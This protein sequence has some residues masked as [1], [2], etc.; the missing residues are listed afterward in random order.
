MTGL[1][2]HTLYTSNIIR[3]VWNYP[4]PV[5]KSQRYLSKIH[6]FLGI[7]RRAIDRLTVFSY[8]ES[9]TALRKIFEPEI[10]ESTRDRCH[11][12]TAYI[13]DK[14]AGN[15][16][17]YFTRFRIIDCSRIRIELS[18]GRSPQYRPAGLQAYHWRVRTDT[19]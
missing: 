16:G 7:Y 1:V 10:T 2:T 17:F 18:A 9:E 6:V 12:F 5:T 4:V 11:C 19:R 13:I 15:S 3:S 14:S 8:F